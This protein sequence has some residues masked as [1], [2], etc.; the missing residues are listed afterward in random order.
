MT[1]PLEHKFE[2]LIQEIDQAILQVDSNQLVDLEHLHQ[3][4]N[5]VCSAA[6]IAEAA[7][8]K[9]LQ[10]PMARLILKLDELANCIKAY[11][12]RLQKVN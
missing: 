1:N 3:E 6:H 10:Q 9:Q 2:Q 11:Q 12:E 5:N 7:L 8:A 4:I